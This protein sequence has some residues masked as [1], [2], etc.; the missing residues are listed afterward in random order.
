MASSA[1]KR[2]PVETEG[3]IASN[4]APILLIQTSLDMWVYLQHEN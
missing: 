2:N 4:V 1:E 3:W